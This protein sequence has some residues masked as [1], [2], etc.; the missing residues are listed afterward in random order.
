MNGI[1]NSILT[2]V[3]GGILLAAVYHS[4][5]FVHNRLRLIGYYS[6]YLWSAFAYC[7][8]RSIYPAHVPLNPWF[9]P[10]EVVQMISFALYIRFT[11]VAMEIQPQ[12]EPLTYWFCKR[13]PLIVFIYL[14]GS[15]VVYH[16]FY[17]HFLSV[18][19]YQLFMYAIRV[20]LLIV[21]LAGLIVVVQ[22][23]NNIY[24]RYIALAI[25]SI[26]AT[27][28][29]STILQIEQFYPFH[30]SALQVL[31]VG[32]A[33]DVCFFSAAVSY[34]M[35]METVEKEAAN[36]QILVQQLALQKAET[37]RIEDY[38]K[39]KEEE[40]SRI[41]MELH[42]EVGSTLSS[43]SILSEV[44][45]KEQNET[46]RDAMQQEVSIN[47]KLMM[48]KIDDIIFSL[49][50]HNDSMEK[51][52]F[53]IRQF[54]TPLFE[55]KSIDYQF[56]F[57]LE[58]YSASISSEVR[59]QLYLILKEGINNLVKHAACSLAKVSAVLVDDALQCSI[60][61]NGK[62]FD[63]TTEFT[64]N[65]LFSMK[66]RAEKIGAILEMVSIPGIETSVLLR[67]KIG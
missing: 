42:D 10:D 22:K 14:L 64:G 66:N 21:G 27:G 50:P 52:L 17:T 24:F 23:R 47:S 18:V 4:V 9:E 54:A 39:A 34:K 29:I 30:H 37:A 60:T 41:A 5:L 11:K 36:R 59:Q 40:R 63:A 56:E 45:M 19:W 67:L 6:V 8:L 46:S 33:I 53:R 44:I 58:V 32:Y 61:D 16:L 15:S 12:R 7:L 57:A 48:E 25:F 26:I 51:M 62:G 13:G 31:A 1:A 28:L 55:A 20:F 2:M 49:N 43:I 35:R 65:G 38:Y 3:A